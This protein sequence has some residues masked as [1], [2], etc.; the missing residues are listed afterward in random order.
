[1]ISILTRTLEARSDEHGIHPPDLMRSRFMLEHARIGITEVRLSAMTTNVYSN[2]LVGMPRF[3]EE[4][5]P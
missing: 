2:L 4:I 5:L 1:M 3:S